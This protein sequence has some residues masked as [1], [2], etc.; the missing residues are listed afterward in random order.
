MLTVAKDVK[1]CHLEHFCAIRWGASPRSQKITSC[2]LKNKLITSRVISEQIIENPEITTIFSP[3]SI[4]IFHKRSTDSSYSVGERVI[5]ESRAL[6]RDLD[7]NTASSGT[8]G[9][10]LPQWQRSVFY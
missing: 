10:T 8:N 4:K 9:P 7:V 5:E 2:T 6:E 3:I 1:L